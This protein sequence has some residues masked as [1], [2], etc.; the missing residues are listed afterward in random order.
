MT[1]DGYSELP[2]LGSPSFTPLLLRY[3]SSHLGSRGW[4]INPSLFSILLLALIVR[5]GGIV[6]DVTKMDIVNVER[7][8]TAMV[9][10]IFGL[11]V[12]YLSIHEDLEPEELVDMLMH[13][14]ITH[15][16][17]LP[18]TP[19]DTP[20]PPNA[21]KWREEQI[22]RPEV[23]IITGLEKASSPVRVKLGDIM[24]KK[25]IDIPSDS[26]K[27]VSLA[28]VDHVN[29]TKSEKKFDPLVIWI[30][31]EG[32]EIPSF[33]IDQFMLGIT[34][35]PENN[36]LPPSDIDGSGI[37][38]FDYIN[39]LTSLLPYVH[40]HPPL[41]VHISNLLSAI[42]SHP[43]LKSVITG[44]ATRSFPEYI[45]AHRLLS[46]SFEIPS[47]F[48]VVSSI[49]DE[50]RLKDTK[51]LGGGVGG[52]D[53]WASLA[54]E[55]P[56]LSTLS[57]DHDI[58]DPFATPNNVEGIWRVFMKH[59]CRKRHETEEVMWLIKGSATENKM[60]KRKNGKGRGVDKILDEI[61]RTV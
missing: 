54:G 29:M 2:N 19:G 4:S 6:I 50:D 32:E 10:S 40:I 38:P 21:Y 12:H 42:S 51:G 11:H 59:R 61:I 52:V 1:I 30:R 37:I 49:S 43:S 9:K 26:Q 14:P 57:S 16:S 48:Q 18:D 41:Q 25:K 28:E 44:K 27:D 15:L 53:T 39:T 31:E 60:P 34:L 45:K 35:E 22:E 58:E 13:P 5:R 17:S 8:I 20:P 47:S 56:S 55:Q 24:V 23:L 36:G 46:G 7:M 3:V 33:L